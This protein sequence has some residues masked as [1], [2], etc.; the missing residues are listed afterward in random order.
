MGRQF[1]IALNRDVSGASGLAR[2]GAARI[3]I[4]AIG[5][6]IGFAPFGTVP[7][8]VRG[9]FNLRIL[10]F[11]TIFE[12]KF[13]AKLHGTGRAIFNAPSAGDAFGFLH[14][15]DIGAAGQVRGIE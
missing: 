4:D 13:L 10:D 8:G 2:S 1:E 14:V 6:V 5:I 11:A 3:A 12:A 9:V 15:S 7:L